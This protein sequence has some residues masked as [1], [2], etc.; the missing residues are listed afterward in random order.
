MT[1]KGINM[2][3]E[4]SIVMT[5]YLAIIIPITRLGLFFIFYIMYDVNKKSYNV[6]ITM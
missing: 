3:S 4:I 6:Y 1:E 5:L 2:Y